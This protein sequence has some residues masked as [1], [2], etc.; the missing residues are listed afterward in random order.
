[1]TPERWRQVEEIFHAALEREGHDRR[2]FVDQAC[3]GDAD[4]R[5]RVQAL[6]ASDQNTSEFMDAPLAKLAAAAGL[7]DSGGLVPGNPPKPDS[8]ET[9]TGRRAGPYQILQQI[10]H[11]GM[12]AV[13]LAERS[14]GQY[15]KQVAIKFVRPGFRSDLFIQRFRNERQVYGGSRA[16]EHRAPSGRGRY[17][18]RPSLPGD[19]ARS[20]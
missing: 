9:L 16:S 14:D 3:A 10:G 11:V 1:M 20:G 17:R 12:G 5:T 4:L 19:G 6:L 18:T 8:A 2:V 13:Y 7:G 15:R